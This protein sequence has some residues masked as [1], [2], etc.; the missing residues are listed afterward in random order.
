[1]KVFKGAAE[2]QLS[3]LMINRIL[4]APRKSRLLLPWALA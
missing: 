4:A 3:F 1:V 2:V